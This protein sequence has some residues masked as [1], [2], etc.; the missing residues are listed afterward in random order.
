RIGG[1]PC[2]PPDPQPVGEAAASCGLPF[3][4]LC[5]L[6]FTVA[7]NCRG[8]RAGKSAVRLGLRQRDMGSG[9][10]HLDP[11]HDAR[12]CRPRVVDAPARAAP[13]PAASRAQSSRRGEEAVT[14]TR[15]FA[16]AVFVVD[17]GRVLLLYHAKLAKWL[18]P[19]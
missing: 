12:L 16:V 17:Q 1:G 7:R 6:L 10:F 11:P 9:L 18:P 15:D 8:D 14:I 13:R 3:R 19:G 2:H 5:L 4:L